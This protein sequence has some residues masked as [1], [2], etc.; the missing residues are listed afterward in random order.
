MAEIRPL[1]AL[2]YDLGAVSS[3]E[4]V[5]APPYDVID[6]GRRAELL[7]RSPFNV[8]ELDLPVAPERR[9]PL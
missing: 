7:A 2:H 5:L 1:R 8:V 4:D 9:R 6:A 3:L